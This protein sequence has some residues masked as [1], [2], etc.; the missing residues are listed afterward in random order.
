MPPMATLTCTQV[1]EVF[2]HV[3]STVMQLAETDPLYICLQQN[4]V[5]NIFDLISI[6]TGEIPTLT[7][8]NAEKNVFP[9]NCGEI[10]LFHA[11]I[12]FILYR[13]AIGDPLTMQAGLM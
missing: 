2:S 10:G 1:T 11:F 8:K 4:G 13:S 5:T 3:I 7:Y 12:G 6:R 9:L